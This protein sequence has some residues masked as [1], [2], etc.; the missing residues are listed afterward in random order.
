MLPKVTADGAAFEDKI[1]EIAE[2]AEL[3]G[4]RR[5]DFHAKANFCRRQHADLGKTVPARHV[6]CPRRV[7]ERDRIAAKH[8]AHDIVEQDIGLLAGEKGGRFSQGCLFLRQAFTANGAARHQFRRAG[9]GVR[10]AKPRRLVYFLAPPPVLTD[11]AGCCRSSVVEHS[12]G[13]GEVERSIRSGST[14]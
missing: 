3:V 12:L 1:D 2:R 5:A 9:S 11:I 14:I 8:I 6:V 4:F 7:L 10:L 13:K